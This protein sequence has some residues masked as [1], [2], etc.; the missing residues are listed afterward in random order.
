MACA[1][2][3]K[4]VVAIERLPLSRTFIVP[5]RKYVVTSEF[6]ALVT[7]WAYAYFST[8]RYMKF[9]GGERSLS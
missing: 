4:L 1:T 8:H 5:S 9:E 6:L 3:Q 2:D 7:V